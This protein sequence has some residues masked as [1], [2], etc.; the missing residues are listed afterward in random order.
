MT[1]KGPFSSARCL[2]HRHRWVLT[3]CLGTK[4]LERDPANIGKGTDAAARPRL[5][6]VLVAEHCNLA[7]LA[8]ATDHPL[9][10]DLHN[11]LVAFFA[12]VTAL[13]VDTYWVSET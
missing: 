2:L 4:S 3:R 13:P 12:F 1:E 7:L 8:I 5:Q 6:W 10:H 9:N 11:I